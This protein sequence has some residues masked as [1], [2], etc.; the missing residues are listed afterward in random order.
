[1]RSAFMMQIPVL[2]MEQPLIQE[3]LPILLIFLLQ[4][5]PAVYC[6][7]STGCLF[8]P[9]TKMEYG[10]CTKEEPFT[11]M[12]RQ[13]LRRIRLLQQNGSSIWIRELAMAF[14]Y[15]QVRQTTQLILL[16]LPGHLH[17]CPGSI[18]YFCVY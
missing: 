9:G 3:R 8:E 15:Q 7:D 1:M 13:L 14:P 17:Y 2:A 6:R 4:L 5:I 11:S 16:Q 12:R 10:A 18:A